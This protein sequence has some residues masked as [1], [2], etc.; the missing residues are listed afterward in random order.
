[1]TFDDTIGDVLR[2][3]GGYVNDPLDRGGETNFG[4]TI[5]TARAN[6]YTGAIVDL[7]RKL[8]TD[9]YWRKYIVAPGFD[10]VG[11][12]S[13]PIAAELVDTGVNMGPAVAAKFLQRTL[14]VLNNQARDYPDIGV[15]GDIGRATIGALRAFI[16]K[17][18]A[19]GE[20]RMLKALDALQGNRYIE[21]AEGRATNE[22]YMF[23]WL[24]RVS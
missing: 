20:L 1:M 14:N 4:I 2:R 19:L 7:P 16:A 24:E 18:G 22:K 6:G 15:D 21:L 12:V 9:I 10:K 17:R 23:G 11:A 13:M 8:A 3:E 5:A